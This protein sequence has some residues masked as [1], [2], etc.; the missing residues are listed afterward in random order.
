MKHAILLAAALLVFTHAAQAQPGT[1]WAAVGSTGTSA[2]CPATGSPT[3]QAYVSAYNT[4]LNATPQPALTQPFANDLQLVGAEANWIENC[5][6]TGTCVYNSVPI[7]EAFVSNILQK[8]GA[9]GVVWN[10]DYMPYMMSPEYIAATGFSC[11]ATYA[12]STCTRLTTNLAF[13]DAI[14]PWIAAQGLTLRL[15]PISFGVPGGGA[16]WLICGLTPSTMTVAQ[17]L[18][19]E[20]PFLAAMV[21][22][23]HNLSPSV[24]FHTIIAA[25]EPVEADN[26]STGQTLST[27]DWNTLIAGLCPAIHAATGGSAVLCASGYTMADGAY[28][29]NVIGSVPSGM[30]VFGAE[31]YFRSFDAT[32]SWS[33][34]PGVYSGW[35]AAA[36]TAGLQ[37]QIDES[38]PPSYCPSGS[39]VA[40][41]S[42]QIN[43]C[44]WPGMVNDNTSGAFWPWLF[45]FSSAIGAT[46]TTIFG[47]QPFAL[48]Q[49]GSCSD[50]TPV[51]SYTWQMLSALP[52]SPTI[53]GLAW[54]AASLGFAPPLP[55]PPPPPPALPNSIP[56]TNFTAPVNK[57][58]NYVLLASSANV[59]GPGQP[60]SNGS[61]GQPSGA[62]FTVLYV[63][64]EAMRVTAAQV[65]PTAAVF[66]ERG[67][68]GTGTQ[69][70]STTAS[71]YVTIPQYFTY[72]GLW[73]ACNAAAQFVLPVIN[74]WSDAIY[75][76]QNGV[77]VNTNSN[78][79]HRMLR[80]LHLTH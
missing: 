27:A 11:A 73:G 23:A 37:V 42:Q 6:T 9:T 2:G 22:H 25:H 68:D 48:L 5:P 13:Y 69:A 52:S 49:D 44:G 47:T 7:Q 70:H 79:W 12:A 77:W 26:A 65:S 8:S 51:T 58:Q 59:T 71:V 46:R 24:S 39:N 31:I 28:A 66:V 43:G 80:G 57:F 74:D 38:G 19:C 15:A 14:Q 61:I 76:C 50:H 4:F 30:Q 33:N 29:T 3:I 41:Q 40:C 21:A 67:W 36:T 10:I 54:K 32:P 75:D 18:A 62:S 78:I 64:Q 72:V 17:R 34:Q 60:I 55:P 1:C 20:E 63:D 53:T 56:I 45:G 35:A 16:P